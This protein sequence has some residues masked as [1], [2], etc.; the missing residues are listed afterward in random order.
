MGA[1][2]CTNTLS[3]VGNLVLVLLLKLVKHLL[4][5]AFHVLHNLLLPIEPAEMETFSSVLV[6]IGKCLWI[7]IKKHGGYLTHFHGNATDLKEKADN[8]EARR[9]DKK[10]EVSMG[11]SI[12]EI[13]TQEVALWLSRASDY[14]EEA[15]YLERR[16]GENKRW[17]CCPN[18]SWRYR[19]RKQVKETAEVIAKHHEQ[20][21]FDRV[22]MAPLI[23]SVV[24]QRNLLNKD[25]ALEESVENIVIRETTP[26][27]VKYT[28]QLTEDLPSVK[29]AMKKVMA[30]LDDKKTKIIGVWGMA[31][32]GKT[33]LVKILNNRM[34]G[35]QHFNKVIMLTVPKEGDLIKRVQDNIANRLGFT[36]RNEYLRTSKLRD[37]LKE[38]KKFLIILDDLWEHL[39]LD[40]VGIPRDD[41]LE[42][43]KI[44]LTTRNV[45]VCR[46]MGTDVNIKVEALLNDES[47]KL[48]R[49]KAGDVVDD[50]TVHTTAKDVL[51]ECGGLPL[52]ITTLGRALRGITEL[53]VWENTLEQLKKAS[54]SDIEDMEDK[55][56]RPIKLSIDSLRSELRPGFFFCCLFPEGCIIDVD[57]IIRYWK[58]EGFLDDVGSLDETFKRG[59]SWVEE[60]K[61]SCLL[62]DW[63]KGHVKMHD[64]VRDVA[65]WI[66]SRDHEYRSLVRAGL[67]LKDLSQVQKWHGYKRISLMN[68][69][70]TE[71]PKG[72]YCTQLLT[73][74]MQKNE[75]LNEIPDWFFE[76]TK[77]LRVL[78]LSNT[79][80]SNLPSSLSKQ[81]TLRVLCLRSCKFVTKR[82]LAGIEGLKQLEILDLSHNILL[83]ELPKEIRELV[84]LRS[85]N[86]NHTQKLR[87]IHH[88]VI[89]RLTSLEELK[90][91]NSFRWSGIQEDASNSSGKNKATLAEVLSLTKLS[92]LFLEI[93]YQKPFPAEYNVQL[94]RWPDKKFNLHIHQPSYPLD[95]DRTTSK[96]D[97]EGCGSLVGWVRK[98]CPHPTILKLASCNGPRTLGRGGGLESLQSLSIYSCN[99]MECVLQMEEATATCL[100]NLRHLDVSSCPKLNHLVPYFLLQRMANLT[101]AKVQ[102]CE[103]MEH[104]IGGLPE[105]VLPDDDMLPNLQTM[106]L[107]TLPK[108]KSIWEIK[109]VLALPN[110]T[111]LELYEC[112]GLKKSVLSSVQI[113]T[114]LPNL[115]ELTIHD[116]CG[117]EEIISEV[118]DNEGLFPELRVLILSHLP[119]LVRICGGRGGEAASPLQLEWHSLE[120]IKVHQCPKLKKLLPL[121]GGSLAVQSL[122]EIVGDREWWEGLDWDADNTIKSHFQCLFTELRVGSNQQKRGW[123]RT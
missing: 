68:S 10:K 4:L 12:G 98:L 107:D 6:E 88:E 62:L 101:N 74:M 121:Q 22:T 35:T 27:V 108:M 52:A 123:W 38:E 9:N 71:L 105:M 120:K 17:L 15:K 94:Q 110:L 47:W 26:P 119:K 69:G 87:I 7:P 116:C 45:A 25:L 61:S 8:L 63:G 67:E 115:V 91:K 46:K 79:A 95:Y 114:G 39:D 64:I 84:K 78:D 100:E 28:A 86:L 80:I 75:G 92:C 83:Q 60:I 18:L 44:I 50:P 65:I 102:Q 48:F 24:N 34:Y 29:L 118:V 93:E 66:A 70:I 81:M 55:V 99:D 37:A 111:S 41:D 54:P 51:K 14:I 19:I 2:K 21:K 1:N 43:C 42:D 89:S 56:Y 96:I 97:I 103:G 77:A 5:T 82:S 112:H 122:E 16:V 40:D 3:Q 30:A 59:R 11:C 73:L 85:L 20:G 49:E 90:M 72:A 113:K 104:V 117:V 33:T 13:E 106:I 31:G 76:K 53:D 32:I 23:P 109:L 57:L 58:G 36:L